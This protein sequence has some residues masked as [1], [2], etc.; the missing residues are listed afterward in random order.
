M[1]A[2]LV[3]ALCIIVLSSGVFSIG[4]VACN[5]PPINAG[6]TSKTDQPDKNNCATAGG[7]I[8]TGF[9]EAWA[10]IHGHHEEIIA[11]GTI[12]IAVFTI[13]LGLFTVSLAGAT[14]KLVKG[15]ERTERR[16]LRA[17][18]GLESLSFEVTNENNPD[19]ILDLDTPGIIH[20]DFVTVKIRNFGVTPARDVCVFTYV[21]PQGPH[22][23]L[24]DDFFL[25][26][27]R[28]AAP[29]GAVRITLARF[30]LNPGQMEISKSL[31]H[32]H[33]VRE[34]RA[35]RIGLYVYGRI[36]YRD[37]YDR[38]WRTK[39]CYSWEPSIADRSERFVAYEQ[40]NGEDQ[41]AL[42]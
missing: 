1:R 9:A 17:Y 32:P 29:T 26:H 5:Q 15:A 10:F 14:D 2:L 36:Y 13:V 27:N 6:E 12:F 35:L 34:A 40:Y 23:R 8:K 16:E 22:E 25:T 11:V 24:A 37:I 4:L 39:F 21:Q 33:A 19:F 30:L 38:P 7:I 41:I 20:Q 3:F 28:D 42:A 18:V 31:V